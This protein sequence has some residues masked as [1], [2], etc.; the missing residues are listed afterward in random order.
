MTRKFILTILGVMFMFLIQ[1]QSVA[2]S[3]AQSEPS[4]Q[5]KLILYGMTALGV[6][7]IGLGLRNSKLFKKK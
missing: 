2:D 4:G 1:A 3:V 5:Q 6:L 7:L